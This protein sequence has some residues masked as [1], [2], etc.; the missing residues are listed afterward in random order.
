[1]AHHLGRRDLEKQEWIVMRQDMP[2]DV[3]SLVLADTAGGCN[4]PNKL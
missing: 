2:G 4:N 1:V 3:R